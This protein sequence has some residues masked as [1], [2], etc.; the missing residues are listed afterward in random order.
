VLV[1]TATSVDH[2]T[3]RRRIPLVV[4]PPPPKPK[5]RPK[6]PLLRILGQNVTDGQQVEG[7]VVWRVDV[8]GKPARVEFR[9]D[10]ELRGEDVQRP[11]TLGWDAATATPGEHLLE[12]RAV[13]ADGREARALVR[14]VR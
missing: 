9:I 3:A 12:A 13:G 7:L 2:R 4:P 5:P 14:V 11:F 1:V 6:P 8:A 10:G